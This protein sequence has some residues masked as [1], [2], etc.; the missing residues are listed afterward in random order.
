MEISPVVR[1]EVDEYRVEPEL[2]EGIVLDEKNRQ[3]SWDADE[4]NRSHDV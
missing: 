4:Y 1:G 3:N 2:P